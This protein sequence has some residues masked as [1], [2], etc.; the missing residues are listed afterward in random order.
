[1][2]SARGGIWIT[3]PKNRTVLSLATGA[4]V[5]EAEEPIKVSLGVHRDVRR[6]LAA[7][8]LAEPS[9]VALQVGGQKGVGLLQRVDT[10][11]FE[12]DHQAVLLRSPGP[13]DPAL[14]LRRVGGDRLHPELGQ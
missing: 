8:R 7:R 5:L 13:L 2:P 10:G 6:L 11:Q 3:R 12:L 1:M 14:G 9:P 4:R